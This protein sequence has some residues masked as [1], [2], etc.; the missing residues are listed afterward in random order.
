MYFKAHSCH[1]AGFDCEFI[2]G[3][4][5]KSKIFV[6]AKQI[7]ISCLSFVAFMIHL[8]VKRVDSFI[9]CKHLCS[10]YDVT[11]IDVNV[12]LEYVAA[13]FFYIYFNF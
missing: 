5:V 1:R 2:F 11:E 9:P 4:S 3:V 8:K 10:W 13:S 12:I 6:Y 7:Y